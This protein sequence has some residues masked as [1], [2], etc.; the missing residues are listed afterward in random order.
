MIR[1]FIVWCNDDGI[2]GAFGSFNEA[3]SYRQR[4][5]TDGLYNYEDVMIHQEEVKL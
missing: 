3:E 2:L 4:M 1:V 5:D